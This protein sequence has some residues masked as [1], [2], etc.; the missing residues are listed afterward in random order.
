MMIPPLMTYKMTPSIT[1][2]TICVAI[3]Y[4]LVNVFFKCN[5]CWVTVKTDEHLLPAEFY[6]DKWTWLKNLGGIQFCTQNMF[7]VFVEEEKILQFHSES[8]NLYV[9][10]SFEMV[11][12][13]ILEINV[14]PIGCDIHREEFVAK[15]IFDY[16]NIFSQMRYSKLLMERR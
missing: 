10:D 9:V 2:C 13:K 7:N 3:C 11:I 5:D 15:I 16:V 6:A 12:S 4:L 1:L 8:E 14:P